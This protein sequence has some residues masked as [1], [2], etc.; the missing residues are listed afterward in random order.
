[1]FIPKFDI[2]RSVTIDYMHVALLGVAKTL[3]KLWLDKSHRTKPWSIRKRI[4]EA[5]TLVKWISSILEIS[6]NS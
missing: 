5:V 4:G 3:L 1:M 6:R 2:I